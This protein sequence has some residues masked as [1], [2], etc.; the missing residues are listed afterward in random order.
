MQKETYLKLKAEWALYANTGNKEA[1]CLYLALTKPLDQLRKCFTPISNK[2]KLENNGPSM[3][4]VYLLFNQTRVH[5]KRLELGHK[6]K[7]ELAN[8]LL[9]I[10][11]TDP[12]FNLVD[13][14][15]Y[16]KKVGD[17]LYYIRP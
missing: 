7:N 4:N 17:E 11:V 13:F 8:G 14:E 6:V 3:Y 16:L 15:K 10:V 9:S 5:V 1:L 12:E 2:V